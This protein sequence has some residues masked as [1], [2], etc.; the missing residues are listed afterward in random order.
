MGTDSHDLASM[1]KIALK[2]VEL[3]PH[4][5]RVRE[6]IQDTPG[7]IVFHGLGTGKTIGS[8]GAAESLDQPATVVAPAGVRPQFKDELERTLDDPPGGKDPDVQSFYELSRGDVNPEETVIFDEAHRLRNPESSRTESARELAEQADKRLLLTGTPIYNDPTDLATLANLAAGEERLPENSSKFREEFIEGDPQ[9]PG[10]LGRLA[11]VESGEVPEL[12][13]EDKL[14]EA[15]QDIVDYE[16]ARGE[17][18]PDVEEKTKKVEMSS[19]QSE[20]Y[21]TLLGEA[22]FWAR[23][24]V[25][26]NLPP[27][28]SEKDRLNA[29][30]SATRQASNSPHPFS[31]KMGPYQ[32]AKKSPKVQKMAD[33]IERRIEE[34]DN[35]KAIAYS[36][37]IDSGIE[38]LS[39][40]LDERNIDHRRFTGDLSDEEKEGIKQEFNDGEVPVLLASSAGAEG[41]D[42][43]G[44]KEVQVMEPHWNESKINQVVGRAVRAGSHEHLPEEEQKVEVTR[45]HSVPK[46][47]IYDKVR[48]FFGGSKPT[49][50]DEY[51]TERAGE[52]Q[53]L[54]DDFLD[55]VKDVGSDE[56]K[57][58]MVRGFM[59]GISQP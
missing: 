44:V 2:N 4:Q 5:K 26:H 49:S 13:N 35:F 57:E 24:K 14:R 55:V 12:K 59:K 38:P 53:Q 54:I 22:P 46:P 25:R 42:T 10:I 3:R 32:G 9:G 33:D 31:Q 29:F 37:F 8:I 28:K 19:E 39:R 45:Y 51:L 43:K 34:D 48:E 21:K 6:S 20:I 50:T 15:L 7:K 41:L 56:E 18:F 40:E 11:G 36:N 47:S 52:K 17:K 30:L 16:P 1:T 27:N 23:F 58:A